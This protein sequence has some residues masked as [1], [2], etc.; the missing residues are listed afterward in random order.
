MKIADFSVNRPLAITMLILAM[1]FVGL[2]C[3]PKVIPYGAIITNY[4]GAAPEDVEENVSKPLESAVASISNIDTLSSYSYNGMSIVLVAF[5][6]GTDM[7]V[8]LQDIRDKVDRVES[9]LPDDVSSPMILKMDVNSMPIMTLT[10]ESSQEGIDSQTKLV[11]LKRIVE[12]NIQERLERIEGVSSVSIAGGMDRE[13]QVHLNAAKMQSYGL[14]VAAIQGTIASDSISGTGG[15]VINGSR[16][17]SLVVNAKYETIEDIKNIQIS[18]PTGGKISLSDLATVEDTYAERETLAYVNGQEALSLSVA[19]ASGGNTVDVSDGVNQELRVLQETLPDYVNITVISDSAEY[20]NNSINMVAEH[21]LLGAIIA[22]VLLYLFLRSVR[23]TFVILIV[24][25]VSVIATFSLMYFA[26]MTINVITLGGLLLGLGS[27]IDF[28]VVVL[29]SIYRHRELGYNVIEAAKKGASEVGT[30]VIASASAQIVVFLPIALVSGLAGILF[31]PMALVVIFAHLA[32]LFFALTMVPMLS[33]RLLVDVPLEDDDYLATVKSKNP[34]IWFNKLIYHLKQL[35]KKSLAWVLKHR[36]YVILGTVALLI[37][38]FFAASLVSWEFIPAS[39]EGAFTIKI[40]TDTGTT[41][42]DTYAKAA[43]AEE[44]VWRELPEV[45]TVTTNV[46]GSGSFYSS[47]N[48]ATASLTVNLVDLEERSISTEQAIAKVRKC[49][50]REISGIDFT[51]AASSSSSMGGSSDS[52]DVQISIKGDN[53][54]VLEQLSDEVENIVASV[55]GTE[56]ITSSL[57]NTKPQYKFVVDR[58]EIA[59][60]GLSAS[61]VYSTVQVALGGSKIAK[62]KTD[63]DEIDILLDL[64]YD[65]D[66][67]TAELGNLV[68]VSP[69]GAEVPLSQLGEIYSEDTP[70]QIDRVDQTRNIKITASITSDYDLNTTVSEIQALIDEMSWPEGYTVEYGGTYENMMDS[71]ADLALALVL[72]IVLMFMVMVALF[73]SLFQPFIIMFALPPT[74]IGVV[75]GLVTT[76]NSLNVAAFMGMIMLVGIVVNNSIVLVDYININRSRGMLRDEAILVSAPVRLR[77]ILITALSTILVLFPMAF[78]GGEGSEIQAPMAVTVVFGLSFSTLITLFLVP[79]VY[80][81]FD[82]FVN[83]TKRTVHRIFHRKAK[84]PTEL[85]EEES[86]ETSI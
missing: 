6:W 19:K 25:P 28:S 64:P 63:E 60:Y 33:S 37:A 66:I 13:I 52:G 7:D 3:L 16:E 51:A 55:K 59:R 71:F 75:F 47:S 57:D 30:A 81:L 62:M 67:S 74:F 77:P 49:I 21:G 43:Q 53:L 14:S 41:L 31:R 27:L 48:S 58:Q 23:A 79:V 24:L 61:Q 54:D 76:G 2:Y 72:S 4:T 78:G 45:K 9:T 40:E 8:A 10:V 26:D 44:I 56:D 1:V 29:E 34:V 18:L 36:R 86:S 68:L 15:K 35:Y 65:E 42:E 70:N 84:E 50:A 32:A 12:D 17:Y 20:I 83:W 46:G 82:D 85:L 69:T 39:D 11:S 5:N 80:S 22:A 38:S 73:E